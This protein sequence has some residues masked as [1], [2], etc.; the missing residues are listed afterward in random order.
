MSIVTRIL[1]LN[2]FGSSALFAMV[3]LV[4]T[5]ATGT[6]APRS[7]EAPGGN[8]WHEAQQYTVRNVSESCP[9][10]SSVRFD[11]PVLKVA[12]NDAVCFKAVVKGGAR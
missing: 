9:D 4:A 10:T 8:T 11:L 1:P 12:F 3:A 2:C 5:A 7:D 6:G